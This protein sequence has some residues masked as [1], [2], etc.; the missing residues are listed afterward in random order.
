MTTTESTTTELLSDIIVRT[1]T[2]GVSAELAKGLAGAIALGLDKR[3]YVIAESGDV[4]EPPDEALRVL[5]EMR[6]AIREAIDSGVH[7]RDL[8]SL[9]RRLTEVVRDIS[10]IEER[11]RV[12]K[13][14]SAGNGGKSGRTTGSTARPVDF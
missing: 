1:R 12:T 5:K 3:G 8:A 10:T 11:H 2:K 4:I 9:S 14:G 7:A 6:S 13:K